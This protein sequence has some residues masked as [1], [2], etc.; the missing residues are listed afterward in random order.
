MWDEEWETSIRL[1]YAGQWWLNG[2]LQ[3]SRGDENLTGIF[4]RGEKKLKR[5]NIDNSLE[6]FSC[7]AEKKREVAVGRIE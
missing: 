5:V 7:K 2:Q 1:S 6:G 4:F 3:R